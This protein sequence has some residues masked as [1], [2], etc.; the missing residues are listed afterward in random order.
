MTNRKHHER[1]VVLFIL[2]VLVLN[3]PILYLFGSNAMWLGIPALYLYLFACW[4][5]LIVLLAVLVE[6]RPV[7]EQDSANHGPPHR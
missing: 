5:V 3:Y 7:G 4:F 1:L 6:R 2:G